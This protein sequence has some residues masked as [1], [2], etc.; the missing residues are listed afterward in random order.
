MFHEQIEKMNMSF[1]F[2][3]FMKFLEA[4]DIEI[5]AKWPPPVK[6]DCLKV[7]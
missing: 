2:I 5:Q 1:D 7:E 4:F 3:T 6:P